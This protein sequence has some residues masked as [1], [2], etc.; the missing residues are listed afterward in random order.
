[1]STRREYLRKFTELRAR[2]EG[3]SRPP[4]QLAEQRRIGPRLPVLKRERPHRKYTAIR[5][6][7]L[8][9]LLR[10]RGIVVR[11]FRKRAGVQQVAA[12]PLC[13]HP[14]GVPGTVGRGDLDVD[15]RVTHRI[16]AL[17]VNLAD[18]THRFTTFKNV[19]CGTDPDRPVVFTGGYPLNQV[20]DEPGPQV[21]YV[22]KVLRDVFP[23]PRSGAEKG[24]AP[25]PCSTSYDQQRVVQRHAPDRQGCQ[26][27]GIWR[28]T[29]A[30]FVVGEWRQPAP[31][32]IRKIGNGQNGLTEALRRRNHHRFDERIPCAFNR[33]W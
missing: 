1:A 15:L 29:P 2:K 16:Q 30:A 26:H 31:R 33:N 8:A 3:S 11:P 24:G 9:V 18:Q 27:T 32:P 7:D 22:F 20:V 10:R 19:V 14:V 17:V 28:G 23:S 13:R 4:G 5:T 6:Q 25:M 21:G 12:V